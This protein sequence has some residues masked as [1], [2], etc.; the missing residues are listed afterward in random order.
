MLE[1]RSRSS[2]GL[3]AAS[4]VAFG[5]ALAVLGGIAFAAHIGGFC[6]GAL[7]VRAFQVRPP[8]QPA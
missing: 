7:A 8:L 1:R 5:A 2:R 3:Q 6:F 4:A